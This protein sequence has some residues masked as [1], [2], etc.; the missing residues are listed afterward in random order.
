MNPDVRAFFDS[1]TWTLSYLVKD[2]NSNACAII[3]P[4]LDYDPASGQT[5][6]KNADQVICMIESEKLKLKDGLAM[7]RR[8]VPEV[9]PNE[10]FMQQLAEY[11]LELL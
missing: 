6:T 8:F 10:G 4:V 9:E 1:D 5:Q 11:D 7:I 2:P 3:D